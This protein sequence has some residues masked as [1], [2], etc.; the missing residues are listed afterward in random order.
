MPSAS[1][2]SASVASEQPLGP[3][4]LSKNMSSMLHTYYIYIYM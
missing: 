4:S 3:Q 2:A 1:V